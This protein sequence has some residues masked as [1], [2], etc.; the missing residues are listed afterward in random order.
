MLTL[1]VRKGRYSNQERL[2]SFNKIWQS[3]KESN[4]PV[5]VE[6]KRD[7]TALRNLGYGGQLVRLN[8]GQSILYTVE[9]LVRRN[10]IGSMFIILMDWDR[11]GEKLAKRL[12]VYGDS[13]DLVPNLHIRR[14]LAALCSKDIT[15]IEELPTFVNMLKLSPQYIE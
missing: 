15:C 6:G 13:C 10:G 7:V 5:V 1:M 9:K 11:T 14:D 2:E 3:I 12:K 8:D 4:S